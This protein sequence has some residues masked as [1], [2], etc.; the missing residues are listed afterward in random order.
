MNSVPDYRHGLM[1]S[2][3]LDLGKSPA[4]VSATMAIIRKPTKN[5]ET[6]QLTNYSLQLHSRDAHIPPVY[7]LHAPLRLIITDNNNLI[8]GL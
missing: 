8:I 3:S 7:C 1:A 2:C 5:D 6:P 4:E